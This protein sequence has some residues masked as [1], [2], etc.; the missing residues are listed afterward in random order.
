MLPLLLY[1]RRTFRG[2][3]I[4]TNETHI[5]GNSFAQYPEMYLMQQ[6]YTLSKKRIKASCPLVCTKMFQGTDLNRPQQQLRFTTFF[7]NSN[8]FH[9]RLKVPSTTKDIK[10][11]L[12]ANSLLQK[13]Q[14]SFN[15]SLAYSQENLVNQR[16]MRIQYHAFFLVKMGL[17]KVS[18]H[19]SKMLSFCSINIAWKITD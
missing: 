2:Q 15:C 3:G 19:A 10:I 6:K 9:S 11:S 13:R 18:V 8:Q 1:G 5:Q 14:D 17:Q 7:N 4:E 16:R 12:G